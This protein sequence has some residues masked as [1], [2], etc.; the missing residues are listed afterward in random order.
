[1]SLAV[2]AITAGED[3]YLNAEPVAGP[4]GKVNIPAAGFATIP[5]SK[6]C[7]GTEERN[8]ASVNCSGFCT[9]H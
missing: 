4:V 7:T 3:T 6:G 2:L 5:P 1:M 8:N 9:F